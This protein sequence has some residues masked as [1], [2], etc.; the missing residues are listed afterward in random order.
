[1]WSF[2][3]QTSLSKEGIVPKRIVRFVVRRSRRLVGWIKCSLRR[4]F[5]IACPWQEVEIGED[6]P[7]RRGRICGSCKRE[8]IEEENGGEGNDS[9]FRCGNPI[10]DGA[11]YVKASG[12][13]VSHFGCTIGAL[14]DALDSDGDV[15]IPGGKVTTLPVSNCCGGLETGC[16]KESKEEAR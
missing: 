10:R 15:R 5:R 16:R 4:L 3:T 6:G 7:L 11:P 8:E 13:R 9:C 14:A 1:M 2:S 12:S